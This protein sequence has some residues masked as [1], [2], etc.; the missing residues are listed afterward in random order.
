MAVA[1]WCFIFVLQLEARDVYSYTCT[2]VS[3]AAVGGHLQVAICF[4][5]ARAQFASATVSAH[6]WHAACNCGFCLGEAACSGEGGCLEG[7][8]QEEGLMV[9]AFKV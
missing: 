2:R 1:Y 4:L 3:L 8:S 5:E 6:A 9:H 7:T